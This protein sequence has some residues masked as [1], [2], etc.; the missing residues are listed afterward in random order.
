MHLMAGSIPLVVSDRK[1]REEA[2]RD[3]AS[4]VLAY[5]EGEDADLYNYLDEAAK[6]DVLGAAYRLTF[7]AAKAVEELATATGE[8]P[9]V[10]L[11]RLIHETLR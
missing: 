1:R 10:I 9:P 7:L 4:T 6:V 2:H 8:T 5:I 11:N 3:S